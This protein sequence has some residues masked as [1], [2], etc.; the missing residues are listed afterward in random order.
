MN[1]TSKQR[2]LGQREHTRD[3]RKANLQPLEVKFTGLTKT[4]ARAMEHILIADIH[5]IIYSMLEEKLQWKML[6]VLQVELIMLLASLKV[7]QKMSY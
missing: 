7:L 5:L 2:L 3:T 4:E 1:Y 6:L